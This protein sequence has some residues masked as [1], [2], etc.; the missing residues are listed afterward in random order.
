MDQFLEKDK[1]T[2]L[3]LE[4]IDNINGFISKEIEFLFKIYQ[5]R[6][7]NAQIVSLENLPFREETA[8]SLYSLLQKIEEKE[9]LQNSFYKD[10]NTPIRSHT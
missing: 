5:K 3:L 9:I 1:L 7:L 10:S 6:K 2:K 4:E 8:P